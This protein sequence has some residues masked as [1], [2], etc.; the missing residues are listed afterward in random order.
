MYA[1]TAETLVGVWIGRTVSVRVGVLGLRVLPVPRLLFSVERIMLVHR[2]DGTFAFATL[3]ESGAVASTTVWGD[4]RYDGEALETRARLWMV[5]VQ[6]PSDNDGGDHGGAQAGRRHSE[7]Q[8]IERR[9]VERGR[10]IAGDRDSFELVVAK[11]WVSWRQSWTR[12]DELDP[13]ETLAES[14]PDVVGGVA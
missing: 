4:W 9:R 8:L 7:T 14:L 10:V 3:G 13:D 1:M 5:D 2:R 11:S 6:L 12:R